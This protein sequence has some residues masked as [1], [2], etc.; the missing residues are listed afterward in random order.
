MLY[1]GDRVVYTV[2]TAV[3]VFCSSIGMHKSMQLVLL[4]NLNAHVNGVLRPLALASH[5][6]QGGGVRTT[7]KRGVVRLLRRRE[8][9]SR[10][11][12]LLGIPFFL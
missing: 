7:R 10:Q 5:T 12:F 4:G 2:R 3:R 6:M 1:L 8:R 9:R 11:V